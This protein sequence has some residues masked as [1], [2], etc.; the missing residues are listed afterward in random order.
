MPTICSFYGILIRMF[1]SDHAPPHFHVEYGEFKATVEIQSLKIN[2]GCLPRRAQSLV[3]EWARMHQL[4]LM[5][6]W[7]LCIVKQQPN[8]IEP[9][10]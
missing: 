7:E 3:L 8:P 2:C 10:L 9:L 4:E 1:F 5:A 6:D